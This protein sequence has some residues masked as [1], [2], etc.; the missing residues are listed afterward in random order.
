MIDQETG[1]LVDVLHIPSRA[2]RSVDGVRHVA[3]YEWP[4]RRVAVTV[5]VLQH[6]A[7]RGF[8]RIYPEFIFGLRTFSRPGNEV[9]ELALDLEAH[10]AYA[11]HESLPETAYTWRP[12]VS[13][14]PG[15]GFSYNLLKRGLWLQ[16]HAQWSGVVFTTEQQGRITRIKLL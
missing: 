5:S 3:D 13:L 16:L 1:Q 11:A 9:F 14:P 7:H 2:A 6:V 10:P 8:R 4:E 12:A 15:G